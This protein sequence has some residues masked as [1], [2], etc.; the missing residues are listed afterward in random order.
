MMADHSL[1]DIGMIIVSG[2]T[3]AAPHVASLIKSFGE[4]HVKIKSEVFHRLTG[5]K[6]SERHA[7]TISSVSPFGCSGRALKN[8]AKISNPK[9]CKSKCEK[10]QEV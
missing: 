6:R 1:R 9:Y 5:G 7:E 10:P 2:G 8:Q 3:T 4:A